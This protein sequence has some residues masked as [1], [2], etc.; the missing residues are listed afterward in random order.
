MQCTNHL[1]QDGLAVHNFENVNGRIPNTICDPIWLQASQGKPYARQF[2]FWTCLLPFIEHQADYDKLMSYAPNDT[3]HTGSF[4]DNN[5]EATPFAYGLSV[6]LCP[7]DPAATPGLAEPVR[8]FNAANYLWN[9]GGKLGHC[10]YRGNHGDVRMG[11]DTWSEWAI[12][13]GVFRPYAQSGNPNNVWGEIPFSKISD[14]LSNT[15]LFGESCIAGSDRDTTIRSGVATSVALDGMNPPSNCAAR[16]GSGGELTNPNN[17]LANTDWYNGKG[18][19]WGEGRHTEGGGP[20]FYTCL[21]PNAPSCQMTGYWLMTSSS[22][23]SGGANI[24]LCDGSVRF[25]S[26]T[27]DC[28]NI[29]QPLGGS[30][31]GLAHQQKWTGESTFGVWGAMGTSNCGESK[32]L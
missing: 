9:P 8:P 21:P 1:K 18:F 17:V 14:G 23:H 29:E 19:R 12:G 10:S 16:R 24:A 30:A 13:R 26:E 27:I 2:G 4:Y 22:Y 28:G 11:D 31:S 20:Y 6:F 25:I 32:G 7:S 5:G 15:V 3:I